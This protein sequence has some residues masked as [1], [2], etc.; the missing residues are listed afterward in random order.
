MKNTRKEK[1]MEHVNNKTEE[2]EK[3]KKTNKTGWTNM[4]RK[5]RP[6]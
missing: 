4:E 3:R 1:W 2:Q 5:Y 6:E